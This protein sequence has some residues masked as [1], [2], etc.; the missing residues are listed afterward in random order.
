MGTRFVRANAGAQGLLGSIGTTKY[1]MIQTNAATLVALD[2]GYQAIRL[3]NVGSGLLVYGDS[4]IAVNSGNFL[5]V[6]AGIEW[7]N[8]ADGW[9]TYVRAASVQSF[10]SISEYLE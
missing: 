1:V 7:L 3:F 4:N 9:T 10:L 2:S 8:L 5:F 6:N